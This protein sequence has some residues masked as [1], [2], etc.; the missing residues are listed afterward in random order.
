VKILFYNHTGKISG[1]ERVLLMILNQG[2]ADIDPVVLCPTDGPLLEVVKERGIRTVS[3]DPLAA[4]FTW[5]PDRLLR[6]LFSFLHVIKTMR[7][8][9]FVESPDLIHANSIRAGL[10]M[11]A[12]TFGFD[13]P[14][15]W[16][17]HDLVPRHPLTTVIRLVVCA[18][19]RNHIVA[20]SEAVATRFRGIL[21]KR[22]GSRVPVMTILN[23]IDLTQFC[24]NVESRAET[25]R[26][27]GFDETRLII[28][29]VGQLTPR[30]GQ[31]EAIEAFAKIA[32]KI[33]NS[34]LV[35]VGEALFNHD[36][37]YRT[38]L[39]QLAGASRRAGRIHFL[40]PREDVPALMR[41]FD[42]L[43]LNSRSEAF[44]LTVVEAMASETAVVA[45]SVDGVPEIIRHG[46]SG[47]LVTPGDRTQLAEALSQL[48]QDAQ[49]RRDLAKQGRLD[50]NER[51]SSQRFLSEMNSLYKRL[52]PHGEMP[53]VLCQKPSLQKPLHTE[54]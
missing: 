45:A 14:I 4:R 43:L 29:M 3:I 23:G 37:G 25:R 41:A 38:R 7:S 39:I 9:M 28:G 34:D 27:L 32:D 31:L 2:A 18:S 6:Y 17:I 22:F 5:R 50:A 21:L 40:G 30:K 47:W 42:L 20:V 33:P 35:I 13:I 10:V 44:G 54:N 19:R 11:A 53:H 1:A 48:L 8:L 52:L 49:R 26:A 24:P 46:Q 36:H 16:H 12:A 51:F 15:L